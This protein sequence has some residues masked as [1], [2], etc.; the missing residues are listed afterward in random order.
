MLVVLVIYNVAVVSATRIRRETTA[1]I[2]GLRVGSVKYVE[3]RG[4][5]PVLPV[6]AVT[7]VAHRS[8]WTESDSLTCGRVGV[9]LITHNTHFVKLFHLSNEIQV[10]LGGRSYSY[11]TRVRY[12]LR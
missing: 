12:L 2:D 10:S 5:R 9:K 6:I 8:F 3:V 4:F 1:M 11:S 7:S